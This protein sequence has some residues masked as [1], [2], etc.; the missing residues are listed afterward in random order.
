MLSLFSSGY[1]LLRGRSVFCHR[2]LCAVVQ[3][4]YAI[5]V[6]KPLSLFVETHGTEQA[7]LS[8]DNI[9]NVVNVAPL[10]AEDAYVKE[11]MCM[12]GAPPSTIECGITSDPIAALSYVSLPV[13]MQTSSKPSL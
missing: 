5:G 9:T 8:A 11:A 4:S 6:A 12:D 10:Q 7:D 3:L 13:A 1:A 2:R